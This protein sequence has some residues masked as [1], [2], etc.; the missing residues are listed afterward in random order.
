MILR[1]F[2]YNFL[3][4][5]YIL[6]LINILNQNVESKDIYINNEQELIENINQIN[7]NSLIIN[8]KLS[9]SK[10]IEIPPNK[11]SITLKGIDEETSQ[12]EFIN[13][14][15]FT[16]N[17]PDSVQIQNLTINGY[18]FFNN[19]KEINIK[20]VNFNGCLKAYL[21]DG[22]VYI[23]DSIFKAVSKDDFN[24]AY[25]FENGNVYVN[26]TEFFGYSDNVKNFMYFNG[27]NKYDITI[28]YSNFD[29]NYM[30]SHV[31]IMTSNSVSISNSKFI[32]G[33]NDSKNRLF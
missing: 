6:I 4:F 30:S 19:N 16:F 24:D 15:Y 17:C 33:F 1:I 27:D 29:G 26:N 25:S 20:N 31:S 14:S 7:D 13:N 12:I 2:W 9:I 5:I 18:I 22:N 11:K 8:K 32:N 3:H 23:N 28:D 10:P 21:D